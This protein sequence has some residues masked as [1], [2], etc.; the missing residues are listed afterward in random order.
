[1]GD[2]QPRDMDTKAV[3][4]PAD[5]A[6]LVYQENYME[7]IYGQDCGSYT[8]TLSPTYSFLLLE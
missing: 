2:I 1:M 3:S 7:F 4:G 8:V 5:V 6:S